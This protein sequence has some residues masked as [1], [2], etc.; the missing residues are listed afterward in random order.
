MYLF[1]RQ[2]KNSPFKSP[3]AEVGP[4]RSPEL[5]V[6]GLARASAWSRMC[7]VPQAPLL[8]TGVRSEART[9][10]L[11]HSGLWGFQLVTLTS[12]PNDHS[13]KNNFYCL[14]FIYF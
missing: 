8:G 3:A 13:C 1:E 6:S 7:G 11:R 14:F 5:R 2:I 9:F 4:D 10:E 12:W